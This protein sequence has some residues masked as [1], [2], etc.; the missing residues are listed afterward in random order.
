MLAI[1]DQW[2]T[3]Q[4]VALTDQPSFAVLSRRFNRATKIKQPRRKK[5][6]GRMEE[7]EEEAYDAPISFFFAS[8]R[9]A[10]THDTAVYDTICR[11]GY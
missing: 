6:N 5:A 1:N 7:D 11:P 2:P 3:S 4:K 9:P 8:F 10:S